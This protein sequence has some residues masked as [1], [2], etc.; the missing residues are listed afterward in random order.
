MFAA[1]AF[2]VRVG[3]I[4]KPATVVVVPPICSF[5]DV[6]SATL[7]P[8]LPG[9]LPFLMFAG[10]VA[11]TQVVSAKQTGTSIMMI[12]AKVVSDR[13]RIILPRET[14]SKYTFGPLCAMVI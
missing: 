9:W 13:R 12:N 6:G 10:V 8:T 1:P 4:C 11:G 3:L 2:P 5:A 7:M 14:A